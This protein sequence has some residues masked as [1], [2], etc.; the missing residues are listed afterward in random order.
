MASHKFVL[1]F[2]PGCAVHAK[3]RVAHTSRFRGLFRRDRFGETPKPTRE[4]RALP[5]DLI[6]PRQSDKRSVSGPDALHFCG[7]E[8][9]KTFTRFDVAQGPARD[10]LLF[11]KGERAF[12]FG[13][14]TERQGTRRDLC[15]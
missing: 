8:L 11:I 4:T 1:R 7:V 13:R 14:G 2:T 15:A 12:H 6:A 10:I 9:T 5:G 3:F